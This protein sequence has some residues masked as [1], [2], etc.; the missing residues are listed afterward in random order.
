MAGS[1]RS[2]DLK[3]PQKSIPLGT[4]A[5]IGTTTT[6]CIHMVFGGG[7]DGG[8]GGG[9]GG[10]L[11]VCMHVCIHTCGCCNPELVLDITCLLF[12]GGTISGP[13]LRDQ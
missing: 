12:F 1:N 4:L 3:D 6:I 9:G 13:L 5:A 7:G 8:G 11:C 10:G 2:G